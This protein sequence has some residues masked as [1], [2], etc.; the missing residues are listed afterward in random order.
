MQ[1]LSTII[2]SLFL[3]IIIF[4]IISKIFIIFAKWNGWK[5]GSYLK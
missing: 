1:N 2:G 5:D 4:F 3:A